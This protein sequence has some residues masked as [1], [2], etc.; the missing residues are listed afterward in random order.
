MSVF[1]FTERTVKVK[2]S[3][4]VI[5][6]KRNRKKKNK[7]TPCMDSRKPQLP[8]QLPNDSETLLERQMLQNENA[9]TVDSF[10]KAS[11]QS[12]NKG[13]KN[14]TEWKF[15][16]SGL[17]GASLV[18]LVFVCISII[19]P[20]FRVSRYYINE[21]PSLLKELLNSQVTSEDS[22]TIAR[23]IQLET[24]RRQDLIEDLLEQRVIVSSD[25][26][27]SNLSGYY[28][29]LIAVLS[30]ILILLNIFGFFS[31]RSNANTAL[32]QKKKELDNALNSVDDTIENNLEEMF[33]KNLVVREK[34]EAMVRDIMEQGDQM[35]DEEWD[36]LHLLLKKYEI[37]EALEAI[38]ADEKQNDGEIEG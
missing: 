32:E 25:V 26:F 30:A 9:K 23:A 8:K 37:R 29:T 24:Q 27:A 11:E 21:D 3:V 6:G 31:W 5:M 22:T 12:P 16:W 10:Y 35:T 36:K 28:N 17:V 2:E 20:G 15:F 1:S 18:V 13:S 7:R 34:L 14:G 38:N 33:R 4:L 19:Y